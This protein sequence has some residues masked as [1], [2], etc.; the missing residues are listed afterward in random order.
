MKEEEK[1]DEKVNPHVG[2]NIKSRSTKQKVQRKIVN[3]AN[4]HHRES[5]LDNRQSWEP[6]ISV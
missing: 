1:W 2:L 6:G 4:K 3:D 5:D